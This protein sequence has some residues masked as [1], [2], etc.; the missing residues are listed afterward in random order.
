MNASKLDTPILRETLSQGIKAFGL[1]VPVTAQVRL[2]R[3]LDLLRKWNSHINLTA[4]DDPLEMVTHHLLDSLSIA[5]YVKGPRI[6]DIGT[7]AGLPGIPLAIIFPQYQFTLLDSNGKKIR[8]LRQVR[9]ELAIEN[10]DLAHSRCENFKLNQAVNTITARALADVNEILKNAR[11]LCCT[12]G[13]FL[14]MKG[15]VG[16]EKLNEN[17]LSFRIEEMINLDIPGL[18]KVRHLLIVKPIAALKQ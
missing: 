17:S 8:F 10:L 12:D 2:L 4:I 16:D 3:Y 5:T 14:L 1:D 13:Q 7:G 11:H 6:I 9:H 18:N 15:K